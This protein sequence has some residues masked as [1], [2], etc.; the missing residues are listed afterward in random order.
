MPTGYRDK[1][2]LSF[3]HLFIQDVAQKLNKKVQKNVL[4]IDNSQFLQYLGHS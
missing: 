1:S 2:L 4:R 3:L